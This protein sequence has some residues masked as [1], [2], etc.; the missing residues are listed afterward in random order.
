RPA[1]ATRPTP[2]RRRRTPPGRASRVAA[3]RAARASR[4]GSSSQWARSRLQ[5]RRRG[6][7]P[8]RDCGTG[9]YRCRMSRDQ[10]WTV[11]R[12]T[13]G[14]SGSG[15]VDAGGRRLVAHGA[16]RSLHEAARGLGG[17]AE[18]LTHLAVAALA[19]VAQAEALLDGVA[20][21]M[22]EHAEQIGDHLLL[23]AFDDELL[24]PRVGV[25]EQVDELVAV[26]VADGEVERRGR[27]EPVEAGVLVVELV[28]VARH[29]AEGGTQ[30]RRPVAGQAHQAGLLVERPADGLADPEGG[31]G[32]EL[33]ALAP[34][35]L[36]D[37]VLE[38]EV[39]LLDEVEQ[40]H[41]G[42]QRVPASDAHH[43]AEVGPDE[44]ILGRGGRSDRLAELAPALARVEARLGVAPTL[45][46]LRQLALLV[47]GE[48]GHET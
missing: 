10:L 3:R 6:R 41:G 1:A 39:A 43:Q 36:V 21:P 16:H 17:D 13:E 45:D 23:G 38:A 42:G 40:L 4:M 30:A 48:K 15:S 27:G 26:A 25:G 8:Q 2:S 35:E 33:E 14:R 11:T 7:Q 5:R 34:V 22:V 44:A 19:A 24:G 32:G 46:R 28:A 18:L 9:G 47:G 37:G 12:S 29:L 20:S 31:V